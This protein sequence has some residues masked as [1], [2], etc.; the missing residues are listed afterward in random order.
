MRRGVLLS[1]NT[2]RILQH[3]CTPGGYRVKPEWLDAFLECIAAD[4]AGKPEAAKQP[5]K[6]PASRG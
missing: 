3:V 4:R 5:A 6:S 1:D 2:R